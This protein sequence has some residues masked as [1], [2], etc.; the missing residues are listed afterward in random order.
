ML[1]DSYFEKY[2]AIAISLGGKCLSDKYINSRTH[3]EWEC[4]E[5]HRWE[6]KPNSIK[7]GSWCPD[8]YL[9]YYEEL[10]RTT[11]EQ[12]FGKQFPKCKPKWLVGER[13]FRLEL[14][15]YCADLNIAFE[16]NGEQHYKEIAFHSKGG[17]KA[18]EEIKIRDS[19][20][21]D[22]CKKEGVVLIVI[23]YEDDLGNLPQIIKR[24]SREVGLDF[25]HID[26]GKN[27]DLNKVYL[28]KTKLQEM[29]EI[30]QERGGKCLSD[31]YIN[32]ATPLEWECAEGH[33]WEAIPGNVKRKSWCLICSGSLKSTIDE[34][35]ILAKKR[36]GK[37]LSERYVN[38]ATRLEWE[39]AEGHR[40]EAQPVEIKRGTWC[41]TCAKQ[42]R[43]K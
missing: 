19:L 21:Q 23:S 41:P 30:A 9:Y 13:G 35:H 1:I 3:L 20:K 17:R 31:R 42:K 2:K 25:N 36:G 32:S 26:F 4:A 37:C 38:T 12:L 16:Y 22:L 39:C 29:R 24:K 33:R 10:C 14:D 18:L 40:W 8:C 11:F 6:A 27:I 28:S 34:M 7:Q 5:G 43:S 15:G